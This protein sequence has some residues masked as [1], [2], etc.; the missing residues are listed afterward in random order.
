MARPQDS[1]YQPRFERDSCGFGLVAHMDDEPSHWVVETAVKALHRLTHRGAIAADGKTGDGCG[2]LMKLPRAFLLQVAAEAGIRLT[3]DFTAGTVFLDTDEQI[4]HDQRRTLDRELE[5]QGLSVAGWRTVPTDPEA[6]GTEAL[7]TLPHIEQV[8]VT[9]SPEMDED[10]FQRRLFVARRRADLAMPD[11]D[12]SFYVASLSPHVISYKG[13]VMPANLPVF[14]PDLKDERM[15]SAVCVFHQRFSTNT[16]PEWR[17]AQPFRFLAHNGEI[18]TIQGNRYWAKARAHK[19]RAEALPDL[20][21][22]QPLV[23]MTGSDSCSLDNM[24]EVLLAGG[25]DVPHAMRLLMPPAWQNV[26]DIDADIRAFYEFWGM[27]LEPWDGPAGIVLTDGRYAACSLDRNG[28]RPARYTVTDDRHVLIASES[29]VADLPPERI[30]AHGR[31]KPGEMIAV[32]TREGRL[33]RAADIDR[34]LAARHPYKKWLKDGVAYVGSQ[35][36]D[37][38]TTTEPLDQKDLAVHE[39]LFGVTFEERDQVIRVLAEAQKEAVGSMGDDTPL[40][41]MSRKARPLYDYFRQQFAQVTN[42]PIDPLRE[43]IVMSLETE[44]G[45]QGNIFHVGPE[46]ATRWVMGSPVLAERKFHQILSLAEHGFPHVRLDLNRPADEALKDAIQRLQREAAAAV[47]DGARILVLS[48]RG[49]DEH[50]RPVHA[51]LAT[52]AVHHA[53]VD[54]GL[55][56]ETNIVVETATARDPHHFACLIGYGAT[57]V[58]PWLAYECLHDMTRTGELEGEGVE[59]RQLGRRYRRG[60]KKGLYKIMSKMGISTIA[61]YRGAQLFEAVGLK[62]EIVDLCFTGTVSRVQGAGFDELEDDERRLAEAAWDRRVKTDQGGVLKFIDGGEYHAFNPAVVHTLQ[63]AVES[64]D[65]ADYEQFARV[66]NDRPP[67]VFRDLM[68]LRDDL[69]SVPLEEVEPAEK[70]FP[71]FDSAGMSLGALSPE[72]HESLAIAM[73]RLGARSN[74]GEGGEDPDRHGTERSSKIKQIASG[75]FGVTPE[76]PILADVILTKMPHG[77]KPRLFYTPLPPLD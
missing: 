49:I 9:H 64:G 25:H 65:Y 60:I 51:L 74:S 30:T 40:P 38:E 20:A 21:E 24:L 37:R 31:L 76:Y 13:L 14:Y 50:T 10:D 75:R 1:L 34:E 32:D 47:R 17:L 36:V 43:R 19:W 72:A 67:M 4:A 29:G 2:I 44:L 11:S 16:W 57:A 56:T 3:Q 42:P 68:K 61:S 58:F 77:A 53:L 46:H 8:F 69:E 35:F 26:D 55:R 73:N 45:E 7:E 22:L 5:K 66:V 41:V 71:R 33:M 62:D 18:N 54:E 6:C 28:L 23:S 70:L 48:D 15:A 39:K 59:P 27:H 63:R 12:E 52:G